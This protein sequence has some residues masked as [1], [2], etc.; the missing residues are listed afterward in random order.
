MQKRETIMII[1]CCSF[2]K[3]VQ[4][5][6][7][8]KQKI[9]IF[10]A[11]VIGTVTVPAIIRQYDLLDSVLCYIDN[12]KRKWDKDIA[13]Y[14]KKL[15]VY[16]PVYFQNLA[17]ENI[18]ILMTISRYSEVIEQLDHI[19]LLADRIGY[20]IPM[21]CLMNFHKQDVCGIIKE[22]RKQMIPKKIHYMWLGGKEI[23]RNLQLCIDSWK[24]YCPDYEIVQWNESNYDIGKNKYMKMAYENK[25]YGFVPDYAR[26]D[27]LY[28]YGGFYMD[29][30]VEVVRSLDDLLYQSAFCGV[31]K[32]Q[33]INFGGCSGSVK[34]SDAIKMFLDERK[35]ISFI[36]SDGTIN[37]NTCGYYDTKVAIK[38][39]YLLNGTNQHVKGINI[40]TYDYFHSYDYMS[41]KIELSDDTYTIH[42][43]NGGWMNESMKQQN[44]LAVSKFDK[45][46]KRAVNSD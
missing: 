34:G 11:G 27:I 14:E 37:L 43:F 36:N 33:T 12:D 4:E 40:Y 6:K 30:V 13:L 24:K 42:H 10:G 38:H 25:K 41:G 22:Y 46:Y 15:T 28:N 20:I 8:R 32:W 44:E 31:E 5:I 39:G 26:L 45:I 19:E 17:N 9:V 23:P 1:K 3:M 7:E 29:T 16:G 18:V 35:K 2:D 21:M